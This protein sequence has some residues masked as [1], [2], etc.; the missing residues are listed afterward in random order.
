[1]INLTGPDKPLNTTVFSFVANLPE[2]LVAMQHEDQALVCI[3]DF[4]DYRYVQFWVEGDLVIAE[5]ISNVNVPDKNALTSA[6]EEQL[7]EAGWQEPSGPK[8]PNWRLESTE[9]DA[10][11]TL[12]SRAADAT[13]RIL[14]QGATTESQRVSLKT[15]SVRGHAEADGTSRR[16]YREQLAA[17]EAE[18]ASMTW[19]LSDDD[20]VGGTF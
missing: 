10:A 12:A 9:P 19:D 15:F 8:S 13:T 20:E 1:M 3:A 11:F 4:V 14:R 2:L 6:Q 7:R 18:M 16:T 17:L 5:V